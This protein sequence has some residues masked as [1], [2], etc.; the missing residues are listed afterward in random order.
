MDVRGDGSGVARRTQHSRIAE[1]TVRR[2]FTPLRAATI[3]GSSL[4]LD[5]T[6]K[7]DTAAPVSL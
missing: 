7:M 2:R 4:L 5:D 1:R 6:R 3:L